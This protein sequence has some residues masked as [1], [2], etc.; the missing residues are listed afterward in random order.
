MVPNV[1][2]EEIS[3]DREDLLSIVDLL[4]ERMPISRQA[5]TINFFIIIYFNNLFRSL[6]RKTVF[7]DL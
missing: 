6:L 5:N 1:F 4:H 7:S 3:G 2:R